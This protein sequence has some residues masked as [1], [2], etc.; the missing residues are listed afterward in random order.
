MNFFLISVLLL[1]PVHYTAAVEMTPEQE[2]W[3]YDDEIISTDQVNEGELTFLS[4][5]P[6][7]P[8]LHSINTLTINTQSITSGWVALEQCYNHLDP[9]P[10]TEIVYQY[11]HI[12]NFKISSKRNIEKAVIKGQSIQLDNVM[13]QAELCIKAEVNLLNK[14][15]DNTLSLENGPFHRKFFDGYYPYHVSL[16]IIYPSALLKLIKIKPESQPGFNIEQSVNLIFI[17]SYF[18]GK[19]TTKLVFQRR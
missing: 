17:E 6:D 1:L 10:T 8:V 2:K 4:K 12:R 18:E 7:K 19:L 9:V 11:K 15:T 14:N 5:T 13:K 16:K 3:F